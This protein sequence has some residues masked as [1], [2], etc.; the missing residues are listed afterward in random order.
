M[1]LDNF[2]KSQTFKTGV[3]ILLILLILLIVF[4]MGAIYGHKKSNFL[5]KYD[6]YHG[7]VHGGTFFGHRRGAFN[8]DMYGEFLLKKKLMSDKIILESKTVKESD[9]E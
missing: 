9:A 1:D 8:K 4:K 3:F 6:N 2:L 7:Q 5:H